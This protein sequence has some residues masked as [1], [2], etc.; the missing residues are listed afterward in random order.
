METQNLSS[1]LRVRKQL[2]GKKI[3]K[4]RTSTTK[5][6]KKSSKTARTIS[7]LPKAQE[8]TKCASKKTGENFEIKSPENKENETESQ[9]KKAISQSKKTQKDS[10]KNKS[11]TKPLL[12]ASAKPSTSSLN[13][14]TQDKVNSKQIRNDETFGEKARKATNNSDTSFDLSENESSQF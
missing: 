11:S 6:V 8:S 3:L 7:Q 14:E 9:D 4:K 13:K 5:M 2:E 10:L 1:K 12:K